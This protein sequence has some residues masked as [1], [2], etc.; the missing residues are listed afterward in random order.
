MSMIKKLATPYLQQLQSM[1]KYLKLFTKTYTLVQIFEKSYK[2]AGKGIN[3][4]RNSIKK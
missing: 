2:T 1:M 3:K 4:I